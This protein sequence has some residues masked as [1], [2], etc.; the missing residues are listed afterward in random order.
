[1]QCAMAN[2]HGRADGDDGWFLRVANTAT[3]LFV[4]SRSNI[5]VPTKYEMPLRL[6]LLLL[7]EKEKANEKVKE[8]SLICGSGLA[9]GYNQNQDHICN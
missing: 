8:D 9:S 3:I 2:G 5:M 7:M 4:Q 6:F 1:M